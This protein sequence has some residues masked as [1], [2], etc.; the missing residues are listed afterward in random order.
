MSNRRL[1]IAGLALV[2]ALGLTGCGPD[3]DKAATTG[4]GKGTGVAAQQAAGKQDPAADLAAAAQK[5]GEQSMKIDMNMAG[6]MSMN[7]VAD[8]KSGNV[9][10]SMEMGALGDGTA[11]E[12][13][14]LGDDLY[15]KFGGSIG[16]MLGGGDKTKPWMH[17]DASKLSEGSSFNVMPKDDPAGTKAMISAMTQVERVGDTGFKGT[18]DLTK[19]PRYNKN[20][21]LE[22]LGAK[23][24]KVPFT[25]KKDGEGRLTELTLDMSSLG[26]GA[27]KVE[28]KYSDFGTPVSVEAPPASQVQEAPSQLSGILNA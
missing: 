9:K 16:S 3:E 19:S 10:M 11:I 18:L 23:A 2:A 4:G 14:K 21:S 22:A 1:A 25:A 5:L 12:M 20:K 8:P 27:G 15:M 13:R 28:T 7:G 26:A 17:I 6:A 24:T